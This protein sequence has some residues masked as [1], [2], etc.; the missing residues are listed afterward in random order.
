MGAGK[1]R[2]GVAGGSNAHNLRSSGSSAGGGAG[3]SSETSES[4]MSDEEILSKIK[5]N[6]NLD[7]TFSEIINTLGYNALPTVVGQKEF[8]SILSKGGAHLSRGIR[9]AEEKDAAKYVHDLM[10]GDFYV[11][12]GEAYFGQ[13]MYCFGGDSR[14]QS[15][16]YTNTTGIVLD[17]ALKPNAKIATL[18]MSEVKRQRERSERNKAL[19][20]SLGMRDKVYTKNNS[21]IASMEEFLLKH[22]VSLPKGKPESEQ[23]NYVMKAYPDFN[24]DMASRWY[25][26]AEHTYRQKLRK[27]V[28][29]VERKN[30]GEKVFKQLRANGITDSSNQALAA[31][32]YDAIRLT[33]D[34]VNDKSNNGRAEIYIVLNRGALVVNEDKIRERFGSSYDSLMERQRSIRKIR[35]SIAEKKRLAGV[36]TPRYRFGDVRQVRIPDNWREILNPPKKVETPKKKSSSAG[37]SRKK[38][39]I[40]K[41]KDAYMNMGPRQLSEYIRSNGDDFD[42]VYNIL[43]RWYDE[44]GK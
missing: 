24:S 5:G 13:G 2:V 18:S 11:A 17:M 33:P 40:S 12:G 21:D 39:I 28:A 26:T 8:D 37:D 7:M 41:Y 38:A 23:I 9:A 32:G 4:F 14:N 6:E 36:E 29:E 35:E 3:A 10:E 27:K 25:L 34:Y 43:N 42:E 20:D 44:G 15:Y 31:R 19:I 1:S 22:N 30:A 16:R